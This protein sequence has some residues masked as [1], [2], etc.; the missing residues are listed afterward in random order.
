[1]NYRQTANAMILRDLKGAGFEA[2]ENMNGDTRVC[3]HR[4]V[5]TLEVIT[6]LRQ[7]GYSKSQFTTKRIQDYVV[8]SAVVS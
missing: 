7:A 4:P 8:V 6:A 5:A 3:L 1:M 2:V